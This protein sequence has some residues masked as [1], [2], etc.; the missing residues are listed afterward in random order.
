MK[1][2]F[3]RAVDRGSLVNADDLLTVLDL[4][5]DIA[6]AQDTLLMG[7]Q[8]FQGRRGLFR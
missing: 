3:F 1:G 6:L 4:G 8:G 7:C 5:A 2:Y